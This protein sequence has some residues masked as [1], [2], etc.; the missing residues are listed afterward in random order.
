M[1][2][3]RI[4]E[5]IMSL[6]SDY[7]DSQNLIS[8][9]SHLGE[10]LFFGGAIR[11]Y[12]IHQKYNNMPR[13]FDI[14]IKFFGNSNDANNQLEKIFQ[15]FEYRKNRFG[16]YKVCI[17]SLEFDIWDLNN[18]WAFRENK[19]EANEENLVRSV[20]LSAD[21]IAYNFNNNILYHEE[22][23]KTMNNKVIDIILEDNPQVNLN[24]LRALVFKKKYNWDFSIELVE[25]FKKASRANENIV[26]ELHSLQLSH[27]HSEKLEREEIKKEMSLFSMS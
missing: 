6:L 25:E 22:F 13:D 14:A 9:L 20:Y 19:L 23:E 17:K 26:D 3:K 1:P 12:Y 4:K 11:D 27:Y 15:N 21:S 5:E 7:P 8:E 24:L 10:L 2:T 16:G 18:T